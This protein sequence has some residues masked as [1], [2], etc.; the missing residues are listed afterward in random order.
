MIDYINGLVVET[1][2]KEIIIETGGIGYRVLCPRSTL[3]NIS[4]DTKNM[5]I[6]IVEAV[7]G[8]YGGVIN[9]YGFLTKEEREM[10]CL[11]R[12]EVSGTGAKK[13][14]EYVDRISKS[15]ERFVSAILNKDHLG[16]QTDFGFTKKTADKFINSLKDKIAKINIGVPSQS[17]HDK[18]SNALISDAIMALTSL[19]ASPANAREAVNKALEN[20]EV[21]TI[22]NLIKESL[23]F[24]GAVR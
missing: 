1:T 22:E 6:Y 13:A 16:L 4:Q 24:L 17:P 11:I 20:I 21:V 8:M 9:L 3:F 5:K 18:D 15:F 7:A 19:G 14:L 12:D 23:K 10:F 2:N